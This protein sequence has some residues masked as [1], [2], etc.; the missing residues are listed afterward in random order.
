M[1]CFHNRSSAQEAAEIFTSK[2]MV[3]VELLG[4]SGLYAAHYGRILHQKDKM[5]LSGSVG[6][7]LVPRKGFEPLYPSFLSPVF[8]A[9]FTVFWGKSQHHLELG[10]GFLLRQDRTY[11]FDPEFTPTNLREEVF[12]DKSITM[13]IGYRYQKPEGGFFFRAGYTPMLNFE[14]FEFAEKPIRFF[15]FNVGISLGKSF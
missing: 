9:E 6:F 4:N 3:F 8:P 10:T 13:R 14:G 1:L 15:P 5:K 7:S 11:M 12:W 2:N